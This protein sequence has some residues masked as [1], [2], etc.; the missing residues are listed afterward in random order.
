[1]LAIWFGIEI[2]LWFGCYQFGFLAFFQFRMPWITDTIPNTTSG[3]P[4]N[5]SNTSPIVDVARSAA[6]QPRL[7]SKSQ[8]QGSFCTT[9]LGIMMKMMANNETITIVMIPVCI[10]F[11]S[12]F[13]N[14]LVVFFLRFLSIENLITNEP[15]AVGAD[16]VFHFCYGA[17]DYLAVIWTIGL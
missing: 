5:T 9:T 16:F 8:L 1:M 15:V 6:V 17:R 12:F 3:I 13:D 11:L 14:L 2:T 7:D 4:T 10:F